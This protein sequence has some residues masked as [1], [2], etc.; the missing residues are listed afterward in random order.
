MKAVPIAV[1]VLV[2]GGAVYFAVT[3]ASK[4]I[5]PP[6][7]EKET[8]SK[9]PPLAYAD[10]DLAK[11]GVPAPGEPQ[12]DVKLELVKDKGRN[13]FHFTVTEGHGWAA[14]GIYLELRHQG[15]EIDHSVRD[16]NPNRTLQLLC[17]KA[18]LGFNAPLHHTVTVSALDFPEV[19]DYGTSENWV[20][21]VSSY[22]ELTAPKPEGS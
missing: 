2:A 4:P 16:A 5:E 13:T 3:Q 12:W 19:P 18:P 10:P 7:I 14:N 15:L 20:V 11:K 17:D 22:S 8:G 21:R 6:T 1:L 9:Q